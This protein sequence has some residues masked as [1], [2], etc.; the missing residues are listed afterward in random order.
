MNRS[1]IKSSVDAELNEQELFQDEERGFFTSKRLLAYDPRKMRTVSAPFKVRAL[2]LFQSTETFRLHG[3]W[4]LYAI[5][6]ALVLTYTDEDQTH[7]RVALGLFDGAM[8]EFR[9]LSAFVLA[10]FILLVISAWRERRCHYTNLCATCKALL[11]CLAS[12]LPAWDKKGDG[13]IAAARFQLGRWVLAAH[14]MTVMIARGH[15]NSAQA[16]EYMTTGEYSLLE[17]DEWDAM[18]PDDRNTSIFLWIMMKCKLM[19]VS[20]HISPIEFTHILS[21][22]TAMRTIAH[23]LMARLSVDIPYPYASTIGYLVHIVVFLQ[24]TKN[25]LACVVLYPIYKG[26]FPWKNNDSTEAEAEPEAEAEAE[27][28]STT[29]PEAESQAEPEAE[30]GRRLQ[31]TFVTDGWVP[32][33]AASVMSL[34]SMLLSTSI[35]SYNT[36]P[37][38]GASKRLLQEDLGAVEAIAVPIGDGAVVEP[39]SELTGWANNLHLWILQLGCMLL[40]IMTYHAFFNIHKELHNPFGKREIDIAH[41]HFMARLRRLA[42]VLLEEDMESIA[43]GL[44]ADISNLSANAGSPGPAGRRTQELAAVMATQVDAVQGAAIDAA[45]GQAGI[46]DLPAFLIS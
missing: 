45:A 28:E 5:S 26:P 21:A 44:R 17:P 10:G 11:L 16:K 13:A 37:S 42:T 19:M 35:L 46:A 32:M 38:S 41:E 12:T 20:G 1:A 22:T 36:L 7:S 34:P 9:V 31:S 2:T 4:L 30:A 6:L 8:L 14:E 40:W 43:P 15:A 29:E 3:F 18:L 27:P 39:T 24:C 33:I 25:A 23:D